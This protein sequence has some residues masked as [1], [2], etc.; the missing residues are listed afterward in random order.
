MGVSLHT[1]PLSDGCRTRAVRVPYGKS[2]ISRDPTTARA[3]S[4][5]APVKGHQELAVAMIY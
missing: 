3:D 2:R 4:F 5:K 1:Q